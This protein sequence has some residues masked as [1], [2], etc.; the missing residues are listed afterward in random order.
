MKK[1]AQFMVLILVLWF[2]HE[3]KA[4][5][6]TNITICTPGVAGPFNF[7]P[8][9]NN[10]SSCLLFIN[11][12]GANRYAYII[13]Y[14][15][16]SGDLNLLIDGNNNSGFIDV[17]I[18]DIT[19]QANPCASLGS[20][21]EI[22][23]NFA[24]SA[25]GCNEFGN[26]FPCPS[27]VTAPYVNAGDVVMILVEDYSQQQTNFT[28]QLSNA[29]GSAQTG[30]PD[31]TITPAGPFLDVDPSYTMNAAD[32][33]G[34]WSA[35][36]GACI[37]PVT[38]AF[39][40]AVAGVGTHQICYS[41]GANPC[42]DD[43]CL[44]VTVI[45]NCTDP[46]LDPIADVSVCDS[47][48]LPPI[49]GTD[50]SG[51]EAYYTGPGGTGIQ[52]NIGAVYNVNGTQTLYAYSEDGVPPSVCSDETSFTITIDADLP[53]ITCPGNLTAICDISEQPAYT[54]FNDFI[55]NGG[56]AADVTGNIDPTSFVLLSEVS[57]GNTCPETITRTY[58]IADD[59]GHV[60]TCMQ[61]I[62][63]NDIIPPTGTAPANLTVQCIGDV[64]AADVTLIT[65]EADNCT[66][67]PVV[68][69]L[70]DVSDGNT[71]P[72]VITRTYN[73]ADD[74][75]NNIDVVQTITIDDNTNPTGTAPG[76]LTVQCIGDV[77]AADVTL[78]TDEADNCTVNPIVT[79]VS[80]VSDGNTCP[81]VITRTYNIA[82]DCGNNIDVVQT[83]TIDDNTNPTASNPAPVTVEC[84]TDVPPV[85]VTV[86]TD[87]AD[88]CTVNPIVAF[89]SESSNN[90]TCNGEVITRI[91]SVTDDCGNSINV[92]HTITVDSYTP[93]FTVSST[94]PTTCGGNDGTI[95]ISG[96]NANTDYIF[97]YDGG[98]NTNI[99]TDAAGEYIV[100]GLTAGSYIDYTVSDADCPSCN[101]TENVTMTLTD[102][103]APTIDAGVDQEVCEGETVTLTAVNPD[104][105][106]VTWDNGVTDGVGFVSPVGTTNYTVTAEIANCFSSD[107]VSVLVH[108]TPTVSAGND[109]EVCD[110]TQVTLQGSGAATYVWD[111]VVTDGTPFTLSVGTITY[112]VVG[113]SAFGCEASDQV[114][115]TVNENPEVLFEA[116]VT[117]GCTPLEVNLV[118]LTP[119]AAD[120]QFTI[121]G[122]QIDGCDINYTFT[123]PG[124]YDV[125]L[126][127][128]SV[129][130]CVSDLTLNNYICIDNYPIAD[131]TVEPGQLSNMNDE[132]TFVN[133]S[134]GAETYD[135]SF[136]DGETST[137]NNP[138][139]TYSV[140]EDGEDAYE[141]QLIAYSE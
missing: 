110:G 87:A 59:C 138:I 42:Q 56:T 60:N 8:A 45:A 18:F 41:I 68:T 114:D 94:D 76:D 67:N 9:S 74:C 44:D 73:I 65:D 1:L 50:L 20:G 86:V 70:S 4:Q 11:G 105:A 31:A 99:T 23:C 92:T 104:G 29:P 63:I 12:T 84:L 106:T 91:Y 119:G 107:V 129:N 115:V 90:N 71:C 117:E 141:I 24:S 57:D 53:T 122:M 120:C 46:V 55:A 61:T 32:G 127:V 28:L 3:V 62:T 34:T 43:D 7:A 14:I 89:V 132:A 58:Q 137:E 103:N 82:D 130:G 54:D 72:E 123:N 66:V 113:T 40:P 96:L 83:I 116:D 85:A 108:P 112:S 81:E 22:G 19:G 121:E 10:P 135:W 93:T 124:C 101:T 39:N 140:E 48:V 69:H 37:N 133:G 21:T 30:P 131:F 80:D 100:T 77:P 136:G 25:S 15:T 126:E 38:G 64:P 111:N 33:G 36:C 118:S 27:T 26:N 75:G 95:T 78:I 35:S 134:I 47:Y 16:Q 51:N 88:N 97:S 109:V 17:S 79:H 13:L 52:Y 139:H 49:T 6:N 102:P 2:S 98:A 125:N 128:E 5:C